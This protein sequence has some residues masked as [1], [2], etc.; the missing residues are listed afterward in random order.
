MTQNAVGATS[1]SFQVKGSNLNP[2]TIPPVAATAVPGTS[3]WTAT[4][5][6]TGLLGTYSITPTITNA[7]GA[8]NTCTNSSV[9]EPG[10]APRGPQKCASMTGSWTDLA[11]PR[12]IGRQPIME[13]CFRAL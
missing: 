8:T 11:R 13:A 9:T 4:I 3:N 1:M 10:P 5:S 2:V 6:T 7:S 12:F